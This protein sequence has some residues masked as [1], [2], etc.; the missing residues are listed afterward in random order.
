MSAPILKRLRLK[1]GMTQKAVADAMDVSQPNYQRWESGSAAIPETKQKKLARVL[2]TSVDE[3]LGKPPAFDLFGVAPG[4]QDDRKYFGEVA[5]HFSKGAPILLPITEEMRSDLL[6]QLCENSQFIV[7]ESMDNRQVFIRRSAI[8]DVYFSSEAYDTYGPDDQEYPDHLGLLPDDDF[9]KIAEFQESPEFLEGE[10]EQERI[11][12]VLGQICLTDERLEKLIADGHVTPEDRESVM[13]ESTKR[14]AE[15]ADRASCVCWQFSSG[16]LRR[17]YAP[18]S[19]LLYEV[20]SLITPDSDD[21]L[22]DGTIYLPLEG[23]HRTIVITGSALDYI[24]IP[25]HKFHEG[26]IECA[27]QEI[28]ETGS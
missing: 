21:I 24:S 28:D 9:W 15:F 13:A 20:F 26:L 14:A 17:E 18:E 22:L 25:K 23:Y 16:Q 4:I 7:A 27:E 12:E 6:N 19:K 2:G 1:A 11:D 5:V 10:I 3:L 8:M